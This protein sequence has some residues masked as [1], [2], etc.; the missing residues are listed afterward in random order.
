MGGKGSGGRNAKPI[1]VKRRNGNPGHRKLNKK[2]PKAKPGEPEMPLYVAKNPIARA[3]WKRLVPIL[4]DMGVLTTAHSIA[5]GGLCA[6]HSQLVM[7]EASILKYGIM[8][9][10]SLDKETGLALLSV[11][12]AVRIKSDALR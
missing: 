1:A 11:N 4:L 5:L 7:A 10:R 8:A 9:V 6:A 12:P 3:E 2:E